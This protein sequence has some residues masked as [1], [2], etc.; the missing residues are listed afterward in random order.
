MQSNNAQ[1]LFLHVPSSLFFFNF[2]GSMYLI[3]DNFDTHS[4]VRMFDY[5]FVSISHIVLFSVYALF[6]LTDKLADR[7][8]EKREVSTQIVFTR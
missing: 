3:L 2:L 5:D 7:I 4:L 6:K 1:N 8:S